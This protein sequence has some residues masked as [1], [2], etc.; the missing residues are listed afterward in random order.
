[1]RAKKHTPLCLIA[2]L[3]SLIFLSPSI[4]AV[5][6]GDVAPLG[7]PDGIVNVGDALVA[8]RFALGLE[9]P[10]QEE[11]A[12]GDVAPLDDNGQPQPD[13]SITVGDALVILRKALGLVDWTLEPASGA[14]LTSQTIG[15]EGGTINIDDFTLNIPSGLFDS[16]VTLEL[17]DLVGL[18]PFDEDIITGAFRL[19]GLPDDYAQP[20]IPDIEYTGTLSD[21]SF[22]VVSEEVLIPSL[23]TGGMA[24]HLFPASD[25][26]GFLTY[27]SSNGSRSVTAYDHS[28]RS[29]GNSSFLDF[30]G[31]T[32]WATYSTGDNSRSN[33]VQGHFS[34]TYPKYLIDRA[35]IEALG[36]YLEKAYS[37]YESMGFSYANRTDWPVKVT[38][39][40]LKP[41]EYGYHCPD[42][43]GHNYTT[44]Q[45]NQ[46]KL[47]EKTQ[48]STTAGHE[49]FHL[50]QYLYDPRNAYNRAK[51]APTHHWLNEAC[52][53]WAEEKFTDTSNYVSTVRH[54]NELTPFNGMHAGSVTGDAGEHGYGMSAFIKYLVTKYGES[55]LRDIY[56]QI[57]NQQHPVQAINLATNHNLFMIWEPF[58]REYVTGNIYSVDK[59]QF[60]SKHSMAGSFEI[61]SDADRT[62]TFTEQYPDLSATLFMI[63][64][65][66]PEIDKTA[67]ITL[68]IDQDVCDITAF[69]VSNAIE[70]LDHAPDK[71]LTIPDIRT[72]TD[73]GY[74]LLVM[75]TN[76]NYKEPYT[77]LTT[78]KL[79]I[80]VLMPGTVTVS[81][82]TDKL[83]ADGSATTVITAT[84][85]DTDGNNIADGTEVKFAA[86]SG[87]LSATTATTT[88]GE[89]TVT[90]TSPTTIGSADIT[91]SVGK[92][93]GSSKI[94]FIS[95][96]CPQTAID[97]YYIIFNPD[98]DPDKLVCE[99]M[100]MWT[101]GYR[102]L[103][104][105]TPYKDGKRNGVE[106]M[107][108]PG[109][110]LRGEIPWYDDNKVNGILRWYYE[111]GQVRE[112]YP[113]VN[114]ILNGIE[115][116]YYENGQLWY[117]I[118]WV[119]SK[120]NGTE[121][122]YYEDGKLSKEIPYV[123]GK[124]NG[125]EK[126][127]Y[128]S[129]QLSHKVGW[130]DGFLH[131]QNIEYSED[132]KIIFCEIRENGIL[133]GS[134][135]PQSQ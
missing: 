35:D 23:A 123:D 18:L 120:K 89:A 106:K 126:W 16:D 77:N 36:Q 34:I 54:G 104:K 110:Q 111:N 50:V 15:T 26:S 91:A 10:S 130:L 31:I 133:V 98:G 40:K 68:T 9:T 93:S 7:A 103:G 41:H 92:I 82:G 12:H 101:G 118:P 20:L 46:D 131:G 44:L 117:Q 47:G 56:V 80:K 38:V 128:E 13:G 79:D 2:L 95:Q 113:Y 75:V 105:E 6:D 122:Y 55:I 69:K 19:E 65:D 11:V 49:F 85:K 37:T 42:W 114:N 86:T 129:G 52:A 21:E 3:F 14:L 63:K 66:Y 45:F 48:L 8:L 124:K 67:A 30:F 135:M 28:S 87:N 109:G 61:K 5:P 102:D 53:V 51:F 24:Y 116:H 83:V 88:N 59:G 90:L 73:D 119:D 78:I 72:L 39:T 62:K 99:Y 112:E 33:G 125:T 127:Y 60:T 1:M 71:K 121:K 134:C 97:T 81:S 96:W 57:L 64:L 132:G 32:G 74:D 43:W 27:T 115:K 108:Y 25:V 58:L 84:V 4:A 100:G 70:Y 94:D 29:N 76:S 107:Y 22:I 17:Y